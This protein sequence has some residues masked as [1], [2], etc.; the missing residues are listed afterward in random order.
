MED[1]NC[2]GLDNQLCIIDIDVEILSIKLKEA[3]FSRISRKKHLE[4]KLAAGSD[5]FMYNENESYLLIIVT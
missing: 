3:I 2:K 5:I 4:V 1:R